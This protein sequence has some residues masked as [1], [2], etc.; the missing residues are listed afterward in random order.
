VRA[1]NAGRPSG[2]LPEAL[3]RLE[4]LADT[5]VI[6]SSAHWA[7]YGQGITFTGL[8]AGS[9]AGRASFLDGA[10]PP[11]HRRA[12]RRRQ[13]HAPHRRV[14]GRL[15][16]DHRR[17]R[18]RHL[19]PNHIVIII[20]QRAVRDGRPERRVHRDGQSVCGGGGAAGKATFETLVRA[21][22]RHSIAANYFG[23]AN[24]SGSLS[25]AVT[26]QIVSLPTRPAPP[27]TPSP[28]ASP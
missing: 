7:V 6:D 15:V 24:F 9:A 11:R 25:G 14:P 28:T 19:R 17:L 20:E 13:G 18:R 22:G 1:R 27:T 5:P 3:E 16:L 21:V 23:D 10:T 4:L 26:Q 2:A 8:V 12:R